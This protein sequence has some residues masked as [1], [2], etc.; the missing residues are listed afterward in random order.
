MWGWWAIVVSKNENINF[1]YISF[2]MERHRMY[3]IYK[4]KV[5]E[6]QNKN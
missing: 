2:A 4:K 6:S 1:D 3:Q 5:I